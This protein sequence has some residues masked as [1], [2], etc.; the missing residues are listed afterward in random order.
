M[1]PHSSRQHVVRSGFAAGWIA[2]ALAAGCAPSEPTPRGT[3]SP[4]ENR[5]GEGDPDGSRIGSK[6]PAVESAPAAATKAPGDDDAPVELKI[7]DFAGIER[8]VAGHRGRV[9][10][11]DAWST[12]CLPCVKEF[13]HLVELQSHF[14]RADVACV[15]LSF[16]YEGLGKP[17]DEA[18]RVLKFLRAKGAAFDNILSSD[19][20]DDLYR[21][22]HL[23]SIP[24]VFVFDRS[25]ELRKRFDNEAAR[26]EAEMF[27]YEQVSALVAE[28]VK[29]TP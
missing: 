8:L 13:P 2:C 1:E 14:G 28:L 27:T 16:D 29:E 19:A 9:V 12:S 7:L 18:P 6:A 10:V 17:A 3:K 21:R 5:L 24:A 20:S 11:M 26:S 23:T 25:G 4:S 15:S 22:F